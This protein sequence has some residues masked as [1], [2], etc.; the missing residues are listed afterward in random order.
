MVETMTKDATAYNFT[1]VII[2]SRK[3]YIHILNNPVFLCRY[4]PTHTMLERHSQHRGARRGCF[5]HDRDRGGIEREREMPA[6]F[7]FHA[8]VKAL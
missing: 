4:P 2:L 3:A 6:E 7:F 8:F 1:R 5:A